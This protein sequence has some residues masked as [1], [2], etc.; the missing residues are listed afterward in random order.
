[1][2]KLE[3]LNS[4]FEKNSYCNCKELARFFYLKEKFSELERFCNDLQ[5][6]FSISGKISRKNKKIYEKKEYERKGIY[7]EVNRE[8]NLLIK[9]RKINLYYHN[10]RKKYPK[11]LIHPEDG[12]KLKNE[13]KIISASCSKCSQQIGVLQ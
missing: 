10:E 6:C 11:Q 3:Y 2:K 12:K 5:Y 8:L 4:L 9:K 7:G 1:M 13:K